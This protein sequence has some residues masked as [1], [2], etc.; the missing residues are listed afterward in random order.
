M[1]N[2]GLS[3]KRSL[4]TGVSYM[5]PIVVAGSMIMAV[6]RIGAMMYDIKDIWD[7]K[8]ADS[9]N[10][11]IQFFHTI[12]GWGGMALGLM[13]PVISGYIAFALADKPGL[14]PGLIAGMLVQKMGAGFLGAL[15]AG[16]LAGYIAL[17]LKKNVKL[18]AAM[19]SVIPIFIIPIGATFVTLAILY[20]VVGEPLTAF[21][22][23]MEVTLRSLS[24]TNQVLM[25][26]II[27]A[28]VGFDLGGPINK[29]AVVTAMAMLTSQLYAPNTAAQ[30]AIIV[31]TL[32]MGI[33]TF[34][35]KKKYDEE[36]HEAG[37]ASFVMGLVGISE[38][39]IPFA[40]D[41]PLRVIPINV[42][43]C[44]LASSIA[45]G[46]GAVNEAPISGI[47][48][49]LAVHNWPVYVLGIFVGAFFIA[50]ANI[51]LRKDIQQ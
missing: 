35:G 7:G 38:G 9:A 16:L 27:G 41:D 48:G 31:P 4:L 18:P 29:A 1:S 2:F 36:L 42:I 51:L 15:V 44:A 6:A 43:G 24:G 13:L 14:A 20:Y 23:W 40:M 34:I 37:K 30:A 8:Y 45:V 33:A 11:L 28:M 49:W 22:H 12:D 25:A 50:F 39:A 19:R 3:L 26:A 17:W 46:L 47:Y 32:G 5:I 10:M 21:N